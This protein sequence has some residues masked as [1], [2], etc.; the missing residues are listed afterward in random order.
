M[1]GNKLGLNIYLSQARAEK[2]VNLAEELW[3]SE[4]GEAGSR[5]AVGNC[6]WWWIDWRRLL[7]SGK[8]LQSIGK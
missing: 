1:S 8:K 2:Y 5:A 3:S 6:Q 7:Q 4:A